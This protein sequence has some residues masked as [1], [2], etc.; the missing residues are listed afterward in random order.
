MSVM[1]STPYE[2]VPAGEELRMTSAGSAPR[3]NLSP[4]PGAAAFV[5]GVWALMTLAAFAYIS[6][7]GA[8]NVPFCDDWFNVPVITGEQPMTAGWLWSEYLGYRMPLPRLILMAVS[9]VPGY[10]FRGGMVLSTAVFSALALGM[11][12]GVKGV[13]G[14]TSYTDAFFPLVWLHWAHSEN[15]LWNF[16]VIYT[17]VTACS[18]VL[19]LVVVHSTT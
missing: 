15:L 8:T 3:A 2:R 11:I 10:E 6:R 4:E 12:W 1:V 17:L 9:R 13:R 18:G 5:W 7:Y 19:L 16:Q 14:W